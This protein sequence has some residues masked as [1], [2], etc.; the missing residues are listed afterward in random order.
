MCSMWL[1]PPVGFRVD[2]VR[3]GCPR[4]CMCVLCVYGCARGPVS[5]SA[6]CLAAQGLS[7]PLFP[8]LNTSYGRAPPLGATCVPLAAILHVCGLC[9]PVLVAPCSCVWL[10]E[11]PALGIIFL[12]PVLPFTDTR[13]FL[14]PVPSPPPPSLHSLPVVV[15]ASHVLVALACNGVL[16]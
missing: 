15:A 4:L 14:Y 8:P 10:W 13:S 9:V 6:A 7:V 16:Y 2:C 12:C 5:A 1:W 11:L 3:W